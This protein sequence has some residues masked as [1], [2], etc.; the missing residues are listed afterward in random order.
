MCNKLFI[1]H[2]TLQKLF[3]NKIYCV[4]HYSLFCRLEYKYEK[5]IAGASGELP[6]PDSCA[7]GE[8]EEEDDVIFEDGKSNGHSL[9]SKF[10]KKPKD[11]DMVSCNPGI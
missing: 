1:K 4:F 9:F 2:N 10:K 8:G 6:A 5:L 11:I 7:I 3:S